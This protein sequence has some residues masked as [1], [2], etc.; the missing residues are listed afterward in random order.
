MTKNTNDDIRPSPEGGGLLHASCVA[1][2]GKAVLI[3]GTAGSGKSALAL[4]LL[5]RGA[6]LVSDDQTQLQ[7]RNG[8]LWA[9]AAPN[10]KGLIEARGVGIL[11]A[12]TVDEAEVTL[13]V[14][15]D[16]AETERLPQ[17][18][19]I[20]R[21]GVTLPLLFNVPHPHFAPAILQYLTHGRSA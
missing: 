8:R 17:W 16:R 19:T 1:V 13:C 14:D 7:V 5:G 11:R 12:E 2:D 15:L 18:H 3:A 21:L 9:S 6:L 10:I 20:S 4:D